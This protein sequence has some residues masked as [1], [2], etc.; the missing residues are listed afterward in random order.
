MDIR[1]VLQRLCSPETLKYVQNQLMPFKWGQNS[2]IIC[3]S[4]V[5]KSIQ[6]LCLYTKGT[7]TKHNLNKADL[8]LKE[9]KCWWGYFRCTRCDYIVKTGFLGQ[10]L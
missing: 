7:R 3:L 1:L 2:L 10:Y 9:R 4:N 8:Q 6:M 5:F